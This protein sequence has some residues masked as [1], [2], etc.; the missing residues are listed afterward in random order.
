M[1]QDRR[2]FLKTGFT[3]SAIFGA[4]KAF[5]DIAPR[6]PGVS[7]KLNVAVIGLG[8]QGRG[9]MLQFLGL[10]DK[11]IVKTVCDCNRVRREGHRDRVNKYYADRPQLGVPADVCKAEA[12]FRKVIEDPEIDAVVIA[13]PDHWH[14][15]MAVEA[16]KHGKDVYCEKPLTFSVWEAKVVVEAAKRTGRVLQVGAMQ[17]S[18]FEFR[19]ACEMVRSGVIGDV[20]YIENNFGGPAN[21]HRDVWNWDKFEEETAPDPDVDFDM[22][23]GPAPLVRYNSVLCPRGMHSNFPAWRDD[24]LVGSGGCGDWGAH[25]LDISQ[26]GLGRDGDGPV[27]VVRSAEPANGD[28][29][30]AWR[31]QKG[32]KF[33][34]ADG[35][36]LLHWNGG[37]WGTM[38]FGSKGLLCVDR[39]RFAFWQGDALSVDRADRKLMRKFD[40]GTFDGLKKLAYYNGKYRENGV[41]VNS[42]SAEFGQSAENAIK[43][44]AGKLGIKMCSD[45][46]FGYDLPVKL[47]LSR[48][49]VQNFVEC[50]F[51]RRPACSNE[52]VGGYTAVMCQLC[53]M[54]YQYDTGFD[55]DP[56]NFTFANG[57]GNEQWLRRRA[58]YRNNFEPK[59]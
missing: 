42:A 21:P 37:R 35:T 24:E 43:I 8:P 59:V 32:V 33:V 25:H 12:D 13:T 26:W 34:Y 54:A 22:W 44:A 3:A 48:N 55:W 50:C 5:A 58:Y 40:D 56:K 1:L 57:T 4:A 46:K 23:C 29:K 36:E 51:E 28:W 19:T 47:Y 45:K 10:E 7:E 9:L 20:K 41:E 11:V 52:D 18:G 31:K 2:S 30:R 27:K 14:V 16:M 15:Y 39:G 49:H 17:R 53:H 38:F 6:K